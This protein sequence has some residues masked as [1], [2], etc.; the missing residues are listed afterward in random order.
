M[1]GL[2]LVVSDQAVMEGQSPVL[3]NHMC[4]CT[5]DVPQQTKT[6]AEGSPTGTSSSTRT[7]AHAGKREQGKKIP[8]HPTNAPAN[9]APR[10]RRGV[11]VAH[12]LLQDS[13][14]DAA[15]SAKV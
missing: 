13:T 9:S 8:I 6:A 4:T 11:L 10:S 3:H 15:T 2:A 14:L 12:A 5:H 7:P 1:P